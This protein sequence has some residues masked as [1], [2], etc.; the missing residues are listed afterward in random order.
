MYKLQYE[1]NIQPCNCIKYGTSWFQIIQSSISYCNNFYSNLTPIIFSDDPMAV[2]SF[3]HEHKL[4]PDSC[5]CTHCKK[6]MVLRK[7]PTK[8]TTDGY[9]WQCIFGQCSKR[10]TTKAIRAGSFFERSRLPL[11]KLVYLMYL[12]S[13]ETTVKSAADTTGVSQKTI[14]Q[15]YQYMWDVCST[16]LL[17]TPPDLDRPGRSRCTDRQKSI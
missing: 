13:G 16:K 3:L 17:N 1:L 11:A 14:V 12:W 6:P 7:R 9:G 8:D 2:P 5:E 4:L 10:L 15:L